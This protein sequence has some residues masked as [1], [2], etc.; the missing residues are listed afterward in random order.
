MLEEIEEFLRRAAAKR[1]AVLNPN[2]PPK[3]PQRP[4]RVDY[5]EPEI[6]DVEVIEPAPYTDGVADHVAR[7]LDTSSYE[8]RESRLGKEVG[9]ADENLESRLH[10][11][12]DHRLG[13]LD[14][15]DKMASDELD[16]QVPATP[17]DIARLLGSA[18]NIRNAIILN[19]I[20]QPPEHR[21]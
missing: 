18:E 6:V 21:W 13:A 16:S 1:A 20:L 3:Q 2:A 12:F 17:N 14:T 19:E 10:N 9:L 5:V 15:D 11:K 8:V 4:I 7:H